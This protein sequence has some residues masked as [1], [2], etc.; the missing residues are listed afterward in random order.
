MSL[1]DLSIHSRLEKET[2]FDLNWTIKFLIKN[3]FTKITK[4]LNFRKNLVFFLNII[5]HNNLWFLI[6][7]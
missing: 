1:S 5:A 2:Y 6:W 7:S 4:C 3:N